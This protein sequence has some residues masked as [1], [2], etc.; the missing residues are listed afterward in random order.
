MGIRFLSA[1][2]FLLISWNA[3]AQ[4]SSV[5]LDRSSFYAA[6]SNGDIDKLNDQIKKIGQTSFEEK[7]AF[8]GVLKMREAEFAKGLKNKLDLFKSGGHQLEDEIAKHKSNGE[9]RF[10]RLIIQENAPSILN[11]NNNIEEDVKLVKAS[12][13]KLPKETQA[14]ILDYCKKSKVLKAKDF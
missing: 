9:Y 8:V 3:E 4:N 14:A 10:L 5:K 11:Y 6:L 13:P 1:A 7:N 12:Y 2:L